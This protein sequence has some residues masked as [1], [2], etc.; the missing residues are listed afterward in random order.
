MATYDPF[1]RSLAWLKD[2]VAVMGKARRYRAAFPDLKAM[3][4]QQSCDYLLQHTGAPLDPDQV[5]WHSFNP[6]DKRSANT[7]SGWLHSHPPVHSMRFS[8]LWVQRFSQYF[9]YQDNVWADGGFY[10]QG[11]EAGT[12]G[13]HNEVKLDP[14]KVMDD[15]W[16]LNFAATVRVR[17]DDFWRKEGLDLPLL[18]KVRFIADIEV[19]LAEGSIGVDDRAQLWTWMRL[20]P[21]R[22]VSLFALSEPANG[23]GF[24]VKTYHMEGAGHLLTLK[25][26]GGHCLLYTPTAEIPLRRFDSQHA[27]HAW[28]TERLHADDAQAWY[29][30]LHRPHCHLESAERKAQLQ[31]VRDRSGEPGA[32]RWPF[33][34]GQSVSQPL[35]LEMRDWV[36]EDVES[37]LRLLVS[38]G[39][40]RRQHWRDELGLAILVLG[41][42][43]MTGQPF[44]MFLLIAGVVRLGL[45]IDA[46]VNARTEAQR[47][48][49][50]SAAIGDLLVVA[51]S[52]FAEAPTSAA[53][54]GWDTYMELDNDSSELLSRSVR[55]RHRSVL[56]QADLPEFEGHM[57]PMDEFGTPH[58]EQQGKRFYSFRHEGEVHN[59]LIEQYSSHMAKANDVFSIGRQ[60]LAAIPEDELQAYLDNLFD[61]M[62]Q[63]PGS[64]AKVLWRGGR[65]PRVTIGARWRAG[66]IRQGDVLVSTDITSFTESPYIPRRFMLPKEAVD[67]PLEQVAEHFDDHTVLYELLADGQASGVP[68][69]SLSLNWQEAEVLFTPGRYFQIES[70]GEVSGAHYRF[71]RIRLREVAKPADKPIYALRT[72]L[73]FDRQAYLQLVQHDALVERFFPA[74]DWA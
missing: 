74:A 24:E 17:N 12:F 48:E 67:L 63:L 35:F 73:P 18:I 57:A 46:Y 13:A 60:R 69:A 16:A 29:D 40:L 14:R 47:H 64:G 61:S 65:G 49:A 5:W 55:Q 33:G 26:K 21:G 22:R 27:M 19:S 2:A 71:L 44:G 28:L 31:A 4:Y 72:G 32:P 58:V 7:F 50:F 30:T 25:G 8:D 41:V 53:P 36:K 56:S 68:V 42:L 34:Q 20:E 43:A 38:N 62:E 1:A 66:D 37:S 52:V 39:D 51:F 9:Q 15:F 70:A 54:E 23:A 11:S 10:N 6:Y 45:D 3:T 59:N